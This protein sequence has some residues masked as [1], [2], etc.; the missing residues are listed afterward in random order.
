MSFSMINAIEYEDS[1]VI[2][3][4]ENDSRMETFYS[5]KDVIVHLRS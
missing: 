4:C 5:V 3:A 1:S 2:F